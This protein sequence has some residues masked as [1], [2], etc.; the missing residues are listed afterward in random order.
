MHIKWNSSDTLLQKRAFRV[1]EQSQEDPDGIKAFKLILFPL[2][3]VRV[4]SCPTVIVIKG[5]GLAPACWL[6]L[7]HSLVTQYI[8]IALDTVGWHSM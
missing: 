6:I 3:P 2:T 8:G 5:D 7:C 1:T 4:H